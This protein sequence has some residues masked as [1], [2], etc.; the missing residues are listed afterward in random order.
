METLVNT[1][2][3]EYGI[4]DEMRRHL[5]EWDV[6]M[7]GEE[8]PH[9]IRWRLV[10]GHYFRAATVAASTE[11]EGNPLT[12]HQVDALLQGEAV[13]AS[14]Q[15]RREVL[16]YNNGLSTATSLA[17]SPGFEWSQ[18]ILRM[19]NHQVMRDDAADR[20][21]R[22]REEAVVVG[23]GV[24]HPPHHSTVPGLMQA[25]ETWL[26]TS[27]D[28]PLV[29]VALLHLNLVAIHP[30]LDGNGRTAR[31]AS[32][33][34]LMRT[35]V[36]SPEILSVEAYLREHEE[37][38]YACLRETLGPRYQ[39]DRHAAS[40]WI[41]Y[42]VR[43]SS[44]RLSFAERMNGAW[45]QDLGTIADAMAMD[46]PRQWGTVAMMAAVA[47][48]RTSLVA[49]IIERTAPTAR[50]ILAAMTAEGWLVRHGIKR[51]THYVAGPRLLALRLRAP[52]IVRSH[53]EGGT[54]GL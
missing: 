11:I 50:S 35:G 42:Y 46:H 20:Q 18:A 40:C 45:P 38:Y 44:E 33:L 53:Y 4:S 37:E 43:I 54:L 32:S 13:N 2:H 31:I 39:P 25:L 7:R 24:Y 23:G 52:E 10:L 51:G 34:E 28:H 22:Y 19:L 47:P 48:I 30:W 21:G 49:E 12:A 3:L 29:R 26:R 9:P 8:P 14:V 41:E 1:L 16:N 27:Q 36:S 17:L 6:A 15:A 5:A